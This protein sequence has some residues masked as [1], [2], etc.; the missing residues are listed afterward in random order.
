MD[1]AFYVSG[2]SPAQKAVLV[3]LADHASNDGRKVFPAVDRLQKKTSY[4][5]RTVRRALSDLRD[6]GLIHVVRE[7]KYHRPTEYAL[8]LPE[9]QSR[10]DRPARDAPH[11]L[12]ESPPDL[13]ESAERPARDAPKPPY[14]PQEPPEGKY[15]GRAEGGVNGHELSPERHPYGEGQQKHEEVRAALDRITKTKYSSHM[16]GEQFD[17]FASTLVQDGVTVDE[18]EG[19]LP[20]WEKQGYYS[21][22][23]A[24]KSVTDEWGNY[25]SDPNGSAPESL[26]M[27]NPDNWKSEDGVL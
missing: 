7:A 27:S 24:L 20:W 14:N 23:P 15:N 3:A 5:E 26:D 13:P 18:V 21:G 10:Q 11:D 16:N 6:M 1:L 17:S 12:P 22:K 8:D 25:H 4:A 19:F 2:L 9:M